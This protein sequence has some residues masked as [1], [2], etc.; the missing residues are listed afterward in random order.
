MTIQTLTSVNLSTPS[1]VAGPIHH[2]KDHAS[3]RKRS[4]TCAKRDFI[5]SRLS[6]E[7]LETAARSSY[8]YLSSSN[9]IE[10]LSSSEERDRFAKRI[11]QRYLESKHGD[12]D[13]A[14]AKIRKT[15]EIRRTAKIADLVTAFDGVD[16]TSKNNND[17]AQTLHTH[18]SS[19]KFYVQGFD[20]E[21]RS[22]LYFIPRNVVD[23]DLESAIYS[24]ERAIASGRSVDG[25]I[26]CVVDFSG[27]SLANGPPLELGKEFLTTLRT[28]YAGQIHRI[29][30]ANASFS[31]SF[32]WN[33]FSPFVGT[34]TRDKISLSKSSGT[35]SNE[36][37][38]E[39]L[40]LYDLDQ[41]PSWLVSGGKKNR[42]LD[43]DE[44]LYRLP[45]DA[46]FDDK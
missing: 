17:I 41:V 15:L 37:Q 29:F 5:L 28:V 27:F 3:S 39:L 20:K 1:A 33:V 4:S 18:L 2:I 38:Q 43:L 34:D 8:E 35:N 7:E 42:S 32:L 23:H 10:T 40:D 31:F 24:I 14:L 30:L 26:N 21:G 19:Q 22:T 13:L 16:R 44:Y 45:F 46:A 9:P 36:K 12:A 25:T 11:V 6:E